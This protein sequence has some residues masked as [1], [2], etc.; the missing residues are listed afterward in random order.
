MLQCS[1]RIP[2]L[3]V[4]MKSKLLNFKNDNTISIKLFLYAVTDYKPTVNILGYF[5]INR[6]LFGSVFF[7]LQIIS[8]LVTYMIVLVQFGSS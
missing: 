1:E 5:E 4:E 3:I 6:P 2:E 8:V 7:I